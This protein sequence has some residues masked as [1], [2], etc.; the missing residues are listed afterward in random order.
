MQNQKKTVLVTGASRGLGFALAQ[1]FC[2]QDWNV[3]ALVRSTSSIHGLMAIGVG[4]AFVADLGSVESEL[5]IAKA[6]AGHQLDLLVN[7]AGIPGRGRNIATLDLD[8]IRDLFNIHCLGIGRS[9]KASLG[10]LRKSKSPVVINIS[11]RLSSL[12]MNHSSAFDAIP[13]SYSYRI[14]KTSQNMM[15]V[16]LHKELIGEGIKVYA[17]HPGEVMTGSQSRDANL[18]P[19]QASQAVFSFWEKTPTLEP[20]KLYRTNGELLD[21]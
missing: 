3:L 8:N 19:G 12:S 10:A 4:Q 9:V 17:L 16:C 18:T 20:G 6:V 15:T 1:E 7:N 14:A 13:T 2:R 11:S 21:W 5:A